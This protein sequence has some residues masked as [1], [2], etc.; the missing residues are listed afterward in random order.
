MSA[1]TMLQMLGSARSS[2]PPP[3]GGLSS[4]NETMPGSIDL[5]ALGYRDYNTMRMGVGGQD[6]QKTGQPHIVYS[7]TPTV[8]HNTSALFTIDT[9]FPSVT[10]TDWTQTGGGG[11]IG[12]VTFSSCTALH[13]NGGTPSV[14]FTFP[15]NIAPQVIDV[16]WASGRYDGFAITGTVGFTAT[17]SDASASPLVKTATAPGTDLHANAYMTRITYNSASDGET[18]AISFSMG[19]FVMPLLLA[20]Q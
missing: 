6:M 19:G 7:S 16:V 9:A 2:G 4:T 20:L 15:A 12:A 3:S 10:A 1:A 18:L 11:A 13:D 17:L 5:N 8:G 14:T